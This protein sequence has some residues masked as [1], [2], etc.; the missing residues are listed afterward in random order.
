MELP[1]SAFHPDAQG[2]LVDRPNR[3]VVRVDL[4]GTLVEAHCPNP[5]RITELLFPGSLVTLER[6]AQPRKLPY[7]LVAVERRGLD[8]SLSTVPLA[9]VRANAAV[10]ALVLPMLFPRA[11]EVR[12]EFPL[13]S[14]RFDFLVV[15]AD[16]ERHLIEVKAC[17][18]VEHGTALFPDA[19]SLRAKKHL[20]E[21]AHWADRGYRPH[22]IFAVAHGKPTR[23]G[24]N[25][26]TDPEFAR[27]LGTTASRIQLH[28]AVFET[29]ADGSTRLIDANLPVHRFSPG[30]DQGLAVECL[31]SNVSWTFDVSDH[32]S[33]FEKAISRLA[34]RRSFAL[35]GASGRRQELIRDLTVARRGDST[36]PRANRA[37]VDV[38]MRWRRNLLP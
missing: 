22:V 14:S 26:H 3:F 6:A 16:G 32:P 33:G 31:P 19:P 1:W 27:T 7:T 35:R 24:P 13:E 17:S 38:I 25:L 15:D 5:G 4:G 36:D 30:P 23:F 8:G 18:E 9:S 10:E 20:E 2:F 11:R 21:L 12:P 28:A 37:F 34:A 29:D